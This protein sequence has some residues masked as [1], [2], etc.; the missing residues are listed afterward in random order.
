[1]TTMPPLRVRLPVRYTS[2]NREEGRSDT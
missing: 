2:A 1:M